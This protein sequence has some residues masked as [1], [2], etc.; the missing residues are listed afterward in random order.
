MRAALA[1]KWE[2]QEIQPWFGP[3]RGFS[4]DR[5]VQPVLDKY[6]IGCHNDQPHNGK[7]LSDLRQDNVRTFSRAY[8]ELQKHVRRP[9]LA[10]VSNSAS[11][12]SGEIPG[13]NNSPASRPA[14]SSPSTTT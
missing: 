13:I 3:A 1:M 9:G 6:C 5:E 8:Q 14:A 2:P 7:K 12:A 10:P 4:F 11:S